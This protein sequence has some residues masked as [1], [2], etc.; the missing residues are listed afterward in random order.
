MEFF[1]QQVIDIC[2]A[3]RRLKKAGN[4]LA[5]CISESLINISQ[6]CEDYI[7]LDVV[8][9]YPVKEVKEL[10]ENSKYDFVIAGEILSLCKP[11]KK[12]GGIESIARAIY[13]FADDLYGAYQQSEHKKQ[14]GIL[15]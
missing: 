13:Y 15:D 8:P 2:Q 1:T 10:L 14:M 3:D 6:I 4:V 11:P 5:K 7:A 9:Y 12:N